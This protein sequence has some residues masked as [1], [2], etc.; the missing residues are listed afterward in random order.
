M[1]ECGRQAE[2]EW[3]ERQIELGWGLG[4]LGLGAEGLRGLGA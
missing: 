4:V 2:T 1:V 3:S